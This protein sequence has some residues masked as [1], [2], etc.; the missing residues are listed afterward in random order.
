MKKED[1]LQEIFQTLDSWEEEAIENRVLAEFLGFSAM[2]EISNN[3]ITPE[4]YL[5]SEMYYGKFRTDWNWLMKVVDKIEGMEKIFLTMNKNSTSVADHKKSYE[6]TVFESG[7]TR[8]QATF[9]AVL[10]FIKEN[11]L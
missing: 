7:N 10:T 2:E 8:I 1:K 11:K 4:N 6:Q 5:D 3:L 9:R